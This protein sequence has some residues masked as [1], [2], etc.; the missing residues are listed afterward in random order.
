MPDS[1]FMLI[2]FGLKLLPWIKGQ[3][4]QLVLRVLQVL[5]AR[6]V[7][8]EQQDRQ[9]QQVQTPLLRGLLVVQEQRVQLVLLER[10]VQLEQQD[11]QV[12]LVQLARK[13]LAVFRVTLVRLVL[14]EPRSTL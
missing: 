11:R 13:D 8:Q 12:Q 9:A 7:Q 6:L 14:R 5:L 10:L 4:D 3:R 2:V 1:I